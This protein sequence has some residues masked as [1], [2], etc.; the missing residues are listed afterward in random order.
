MTQ[1]NPNDPQPKSPADEKLVVKKRRRRWP[2]VLGVIVVLLIL[3]I[4]LA[5]TI[6]SMGFV[7]SIVLGKVNENLNGTVAVDSRSIGWFGGINAH[8]IKVADQTGTIVSID[9]LNTS[10]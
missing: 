6:A 8:G 1:P 2:I 4:A 10:M 7:R 9:K 3:L 5:P